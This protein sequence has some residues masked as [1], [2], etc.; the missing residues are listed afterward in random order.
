MFREL[1]ENLFQ[2]TSFNRPYFQ[3][4]DIYSK[5]VEMILG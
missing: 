5:F 4:F 2:E 3:Y 1:N